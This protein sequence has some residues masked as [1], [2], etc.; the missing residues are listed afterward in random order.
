MESILGEWVT[1]FNEKLPVIIGLR[2]GEFSAGNSDCP[3]IGSAAVIKQNGGY[4]SLPSHRRRLVRDGSPGGGGRSLRVEALEDRRMLAAQFQLLADVNRIVTQNG[5]DPGNFVTVGNFAFFTATTAMHGKEL[6]R[7]DGTEAGTQLVCDI[8]PGRTGGEISGLTEVGGKLFFVADTPGTGRELWTSDGTTVGTAMVKDIVPGPGDGVSDG[9]ARLTNVGGVVYFAG[10]SELG[11]E[12]WRSDGTATGTYLVKDVEP[13]PNPSF[14][15]H[16]TNAGGTLFFSDGWTNRLW[17]SD[18][19]EAG[20]REVSSVVWMDHPSAQ[21]E[22]IAYVNGNVIFRARDAEDY[23]SMRLWKTD[24]AGSHVTKVSDA[25]MHPSALTNVGGTLLFKARDAAHGEELW[26]SDGTAAGT[27]RLTDINPGPGHAFDYGREQLVIGTTL[28]FAATDGPQGAGIWKSDGTAAGTIKLNQTSENLGGVW[29]QVLSEMGGELYFWSN[30]LWKSDGTVGGTAYVH[31]MYS[32]FNP[33]MGSLGNKLLINNKDSTRGQE[34]FV[35]DGT[36]SG[37]RR[38]KDIN[39]AT[40]DSHPS[41][42]TR[43]RNAFYYTVNDGVSHDWKLWRTDGTP[44]G[45]GPVTLDSNRITGIRSLA[46]VGDW[47]YFVSP[48]PI[49]NY[50][51]LWRI[52]GDAMGMALA[53][54]IAVHGGPTEISGLID[55]DGVLHFSAYYEGVGLRL[56]KLDPGGDSA[57]IYSLLPPGQSSVRM[58]RSGGLLYFTGHDSLRGYELWR[59]DGTSDGTKPVRDIRPG[60]DG[61]WPDQL[62]DV[63]GTLYFIAYEDDSLIA[64]LWKSN[65]TA[66]GT[67][68]IMQLTRHSDERHQLELVSFEGSLYFEANDGAGLELWKTDGTVAGTKLVKDIHPGQS[69]YGIYGFTEL[70]GRLYFAA[71][72]GVHGYEIWQSNGTPEGTILLQDV[73]AGANGASP[74]YFTKVDDAIYFA[75]DDGLHGHELWR[76]DLAGNMDFVGDVTGD[77]GGADPQVVGQVD[78]RLVMLATTVA[79]GREMWSAFEIATSGD[80]DADGYA[81]GSDFL[82]WQRTLGS[83][84]TPAGSGADGDGS[85]MIDGGDLVRWTQRFGSVATEPGDFDLDGVA[86][87]SDFLAWQRALGST[88]TPAGSGVDG[89][90]SGRV[91]GD[92]LLIWQNAFSPADRGLPGSNA[93][94]LSSSSS[95][96]LTEATAADLALGRDAALEELFAAGDFTPLFGVSTEPDR[97]KRN[98]PGALRQP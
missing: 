28:Y 81:D 10:N 49:L 29:P 66:A 12:L 86:D 75:A 5:S 64:S 94:A 73:Y 11:S 51:R 93:E 3:A 61:S 80:F 52:A 31:S 8:G 35:S 15:G 14:L 82:T 17:R 34:L 27:Q 1:K 62:T 76:I 59:T 56:N 89:D 90:A 78:N 71:D 4:M 19:T 58:T 63:N 42:V 33:V 79:H 92:D 54:P 20:T 26:R 96:A 67:T 50:D 88:A 37:L 46:S 55:V 48:D 23:D 70:G 77:T 72:D 43:H 57:Q 16:L 21:T 68:R 41:V 30:G 18:G 25:A 47:L 84:A 38:L 22:L 74:R 36:A 40:G 2:H 24:A 85:G 98:R 83:T 87:G 32:G 45:T 95:I 91:D 6:W 53:E 60:P 69:S 39:G 9:W 65:G 44:Q 7:T 97:P 13:G